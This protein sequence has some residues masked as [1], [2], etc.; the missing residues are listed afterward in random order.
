MLWRQTVQRQILFRTIGRVFTG[1]SDTAKAFLIILITG[2]CPG[3]RVRAYPTCWQMCAALRPL[4]HW[5][6]GWFERWQRPS[7]CSS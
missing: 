1:L 2:G 3:Q 7:L 6:A 4:E 5:A